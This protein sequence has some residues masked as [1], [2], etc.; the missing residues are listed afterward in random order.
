MSKSKSNVKRHKHIF[1]I[2]TGIKLGCG[3]GKPFD[4]R[5]GLKR[6]IKLRKYSDVAAKLI[7]MG[8]NVLATGVSN[9]L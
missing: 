4:Q 8:V 5:S 2:P 9:V 7:D 6:H 3:L 1:V